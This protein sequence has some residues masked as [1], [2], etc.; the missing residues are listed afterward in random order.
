MTKGERGL[1]EDS[2]DSV[3]WGPN[4]SKSPNGQSFNSSYFFI[5]FLHESEFINVIEEKA[6]FARVVKKKPQGLGDVLG[7]RAA[8]AWV[9]SASLLAL[10][11]T[12]LR[13]SWFYP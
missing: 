4:E 13:D 3:I 8:G 1:P 2:A 5:F 12:D 10:L 9:G 11:F 6:N 7:G